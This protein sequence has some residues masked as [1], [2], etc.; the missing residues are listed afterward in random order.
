[1]SF[2]LLVLLTFPALRFQHLYNDIIRCH[3]LCIYSVWV[4]IEWFFFFSCDLMSFCQFGVN[5]GHF[6]LSIPSLF[7]L[8][9]PSGPLMAGTF[10]T[11]F[12]SICLRVSFEFSAH[13]YHHVLEWVF[14]SNLLFRLPNISFD[15]SSHCLNSL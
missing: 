8:S 10:E 9:S 11:P 1:M 2:L 14:S 7:L 13:S 5:P 6:L 12:S 4:W 15:V 3:Y